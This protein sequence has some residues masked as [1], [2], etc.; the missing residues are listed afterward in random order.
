MPRKW[1]F[2]AFSGLSGQT[3]AAGLAGRWFDVRTCLFR[4][5]ADHDPACSWLRPLALGVVESCCKL[6]LLL[7]RLLSQG[8]GAQAPVRGLAGTPPIL[9]A[10]HNSPQCQESGLLN[11]AVRTTRGR[12]TRSWWHCT[13][14]AATCCQS[15]GANPAG[16]A[17]R[18]RWAVVE[19]VASLGHFGQQLGDVL[20]WSAC[21][22]VH[23][24]RE[25]SKGG[26]GGR[27]RKGRAVRGGAD[28][29]RANAVLSWCGGGG[30]AP[31][32]RRLAASL[33]RMRRGGAASE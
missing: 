7:G 17:R 25:H 12:R 22:G 16:H 1:A 21:G 23:T 32:P 15:C 24:R 3:G 18:T 20:Q 14:R 10:R 19:A 33:H 13:E 2:R 29:S 31:H 8:R 4:V 26:F 9:A 5:F 11:R 27:S 6:L 30:S 28:V